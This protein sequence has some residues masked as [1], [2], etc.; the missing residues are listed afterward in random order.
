MIASHALRKTLFASILLATAGVSHPI[1]AQS[2]SAAVHA[3]EMKQADI[4]A[5]VAA[6]EKVYGKVCAACHQANGQ[7]LHGAF[8][9]LKDSDYLQADLDRAINAVVKGLTGKITVNGVD[10]NGAMP[11]M[12]YLSD[13]DIAA[14]LTFVLQEWNGG[15]AV[16]VAQVA[17]V[18]VAR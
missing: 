8:P 17:A 2:E 1:L 18:L 15:G 7:G 5:L 14:A 11:P 9:P 16:T 6:G 3:A 4:E 10:Y 12:A 13:D